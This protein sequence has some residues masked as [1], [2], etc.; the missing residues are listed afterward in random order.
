M[1]ETDVFWA[2]RDW[3]RIAAGET[4]VNRYDDL[5]Q[6]VSSGKSIQQTVKFYLDNGIG[7]S[8]ISQN[9][10]STYKQQYIDLYYSDPKAASAL[11]KRLLDAYVAMGYDRSKKAKVIDGWIADAKD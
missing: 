4:N 7:K 2:L 11:K 5:H 1:D 8:T 3:D 10:T 6:A 9:L